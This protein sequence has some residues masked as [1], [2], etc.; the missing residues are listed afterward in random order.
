[1]AVEP[2]KLAVKKEQKFKAESKKKIKRGW[3]C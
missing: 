2:A 3:G 1:M